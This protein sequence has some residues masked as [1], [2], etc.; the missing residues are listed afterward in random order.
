MLP[1][2]SNKELVVL[3]LLSSR[4][5]MF[6]LQLVKESDQAIGRGTVYVTLSRMERKG[7][8]RSFRKDAENGI[9][10]Y[11]KH[12]KITGMGQNTL[13][14]TEAALATWKGGAAHVTP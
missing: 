2:V 10:N 6:G 1:K 3:G 7:L 11:K 12:Y 5:D 14:A 9:E 13:R 4:G 8:V